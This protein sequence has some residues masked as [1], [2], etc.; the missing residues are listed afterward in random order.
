[1]IFGDN[2]SWTVYTGGSV[3]PQPTSP[4]VTPT[5]P[6]TPTGKVLIGDTDLDN[7]VTVLD[8]TAIQKYLVQ[9][10]YLSSRAKIA[11]DA[12]KDGVVSII[13]AT[14]IQKYLASIQDSNS[15]VGQYSDGSSPSTDPTTPTQ[16]PTS[17]PV[18]G[19]SVVLNA[20]ATS[21]EPEAWYAWTWTGDQS[22]KWIKGE[23]SASGV[24]FTGL[25]SKVIFVRANPEM[26]IDWNNGS[27][28]NQTDDL[29]THTG[30]TFTTTG[31]AANRMIGSWD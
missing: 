6:V 18:S 25:E 30:G 14:K 13:D 5:E 4:P 28:W 8:A 27:V 3:T 11:A 1:M 12:D 10:R 9:L 15:Y 21:E 26:E 23:G 22:G 24:V 2:R 29:D 16:Q 20:S 7:T 31:W 17:P 19:D